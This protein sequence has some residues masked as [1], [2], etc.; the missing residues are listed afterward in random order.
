VRAKPPF[1]PAVL[2]VLVGVFAGVIL[3]DNLGQYRWFW[4]Y[5]QE[6]YGAGLFIIVLEMAFVVPRLRPWLDKCQAVLDREDSEIS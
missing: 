5:D 4:P 2:S 1:F 6:V 3:V